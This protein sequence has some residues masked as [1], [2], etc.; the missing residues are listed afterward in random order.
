MLTRIIIT[1]TEGPQRAAAVFA[2]RYGIPW[3]GWLA[4]VDYQSLAKEHPLI[5]GLT[6]APED[7]L[8]NAMQQNILD[9]D[10]VLLLSF[11]R[12]A[13]TIPAVMTFTGLQKRPLLQ[14]DLG[15]A[16]AFQAARDISDWVVNNAIKAL[17]IVGAAGLQDADAYRITLDILE[18]A[19]HLLI[20]AT[21]TPPER[22][23]PAA[24]GR[25]R[26]TGRK[27]ATIEEVVDLLINRL[28]LRDRVRIS[29]MQQEELK[30]LTYTLGEYMRNDLQLWKKNPPLVE[31]CTALARGSTFLEDDACIIIV[32]RLWQRLKT[33]HRLRLM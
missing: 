10:G 21:D 14:I 32:D 5:H 11:G 23:N 13:G 25:Y 15:G 8:H 22:P 1:G 2:D 18:T 3:G 28:S 12:Q 9:A 19:G 6:A 33:T 20:M 7:A 29:N 26:E 17:N 31:A 16:I 24:G 30:A 27:P 4:A